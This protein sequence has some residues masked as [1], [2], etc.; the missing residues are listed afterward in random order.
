MRGEPGLRQE[1]QGRTVLV[2]DDEAIIRELCAKVIKNHRIL[3][4]ASGEE[5]LEILGRE[6]IDVV[7]TDVMMPVMDGLDLLKKIKEEDPAQPV[8]IMTGFADKDVILRALKADADDFISKPINLLQLRTT[9]DRVLEKKALREELHNLKRMDRLKTEFLGLVSHKLKTPTTAIS[10]F[11]QN[12]VQGIGDPQDQG[13]QQTLKM[14]LEESTYLE[15]LIQDLLFFSEVI[16]REGPP[17]L[18]QVDPS[19]VCRQSVKD[20]YPRAAARNISLDLHLPADLPLI[21]TDREQLAFILHALL[22]N[23]IKFTPL[24]GQV[25][26]A[27][28][29]IPEAVRLKIR[30]T[31]AGIAP[32]ERARVFEKFYQID[33]A[34]SGQV[35]GFGLGLFYARSFVQNLGGKLILESESGVGTTAVLSLPRA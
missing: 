15:S 6:A 23:A 33:P 4:A 27:G 3:E 8:V 21:L 7:L 29:I 30:D 34:H 26:L 24:G 2:V 13:F 31:G 9:I 16:L 22:D 17:R 18:A 1:M 25:T 20:I 11:I 35:R 28:E 5:A 10:L 12:L 19:A 32:E 14:I